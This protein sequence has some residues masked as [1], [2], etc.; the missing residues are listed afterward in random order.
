M[1]S[2]CPSDVERVSIVLHPDA[3]LAMEN[4]Q[5]EVVSYRGLLENKDM[6]PNYYTSNVCRTTIDEQRYITI[7]SIDNT[8]TVRNERK[9]K[10][11]IED[12]LVRAEQASKAKTNFL[13][14]MSHDIRTPMNAI[15]GFTALAMTHIDHEGRVKDY[16]SKIMSSGNH[17]LSLIN[18]ILDMSR[19][20]SGRI[21]LNET[22]CNLS[23]VMHEV[24]NIIQADLAAR[25]LDFY[26]DTVDVFDEDV[27]CDKLRL[28]QVLL[29]LLGNALKFTEPGGYISVRMIEKNEPSKN[30]AN[31]EIRVKDTGIGMSKEFVKHIFEP[32]EREETSTNSGIQGTGLGMSITK[33]IVDLMGGTIEI[34]SEKGKGS[35]FIV[36]LP[37]KKQTSAR[38]EV[39]VKELLGARALVVDD[40]FNTCDSVTNMLMQIGMRSEWTMSGKEAVLRTAQAVRRNDPYAVYIIDWMMPDMNGVEVTRNIRMEVG[41]DIPIII[42]TAYDWAEI[43]EEALDAGVTAFCPKPIFLSDLRRCLVQ[44]IRSEEDEK[45]AEAE[46]E[47][48]HEGKKI[49]LVEDN[50]LNQEIAV[51]ILQEQGFLVEVADNGAKAVDVV[52]QSKAGEIDTVLMDIQMPVM[53]GY[54]A[55]KEIRNLANKELANISIIAMTANAFE[56]DRKK[57]KEAGMDAYLPKPI[58]I[59]LLFETLKQVGI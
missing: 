22:E 55:T 34:Q 45:E 18:D 4:G 52:R 15:I 38:K 14:S 29:N 41:D 35:E 21:H 25:K 19:I 48:S 26:I 6:E 2:I 13:N 32:F 24:R 54:E 46:Q 36:T 12:A 9:Q 50:K 58:D 8:A 43:E 17:L 31:Y 49:L 59:P 28:R 57:A 37:M 53:D 56:E 11:L 27:L 16:L 7:F 23:E 39:E 10:Q 3:L 30:V 40:D 51:E 44:T 33:N 47:K 1:K 20:E 5:R 42:L